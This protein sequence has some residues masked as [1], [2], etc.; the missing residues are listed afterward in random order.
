MSTS[1]G[2]FIWY[3]LATSDVGGA[4]KFYKDVIGWGTE[5]FDGAG[6]RYVRWMADGAGVGG[7]MA[8][9]EEARDNGAPPRWT[10]YVFADDVDALTDKA[11]RLGA[12]TWSPPTDIPTVGRFSV[13]SDPQGAVIAMIKPL[14][15]DRP[16]PAEVP[17]RHFSWNELMAADQE[18]AFRFYSE[19]FGWE[20]SGAVE[21]PMGTY[22][23]YGR[24]G[25]MLGGMMTRPED[26][27]AP[28]HWLYYVKVADLD[29]A[30]ARVTKDGGQVMH[31]PMEVPGGSR[32]AQCVDPQG[33]AFALHG[34]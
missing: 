34:Q 27:P 32:V 2:K 12:K 22:Q 26:Y 23:M 25:H 13:I 7:L 8:L 9:P 15:P 4:I 29:A 17:D 20:K 28:P 14:G 21:S 6:M 18:A 33:A 16:Q 19:L 11:T 5:E 31:G 24:E 3:E 30:L 10:A 1:Q